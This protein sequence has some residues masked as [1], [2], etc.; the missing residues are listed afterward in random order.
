MTDQGPAGV[1]DLRVR[2]EDIKRRLESGEPV[3]VLDVRGRKA[4]ESSDL[5]IRNA[6]RADPEHFRADPSWA[7]DRLL[8]S[9]EPDPT[10]KPAPVW[11][12]SLMPRVS[13]RR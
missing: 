12:G 7:K 10:S 8:V 5:K 11:R 3:I 13:G 1:G 2:P 9:T 4:W 6:V